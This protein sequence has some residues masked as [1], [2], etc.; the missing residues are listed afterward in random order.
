MQWKQGLARYLGATQHVPWQE[1]TGGQDDETGRRGTSDWA[2][3]VKGEKATYETEQ[4]AVVRWEQRALG[5]GEMN[6]ATTVMA[7][8]P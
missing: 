2:S 4:A 6:A 1:G 7:V 3:V 8:S 5:P